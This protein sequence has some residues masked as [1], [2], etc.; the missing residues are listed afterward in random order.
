MSTTGMTEAPKV[1]RLKQIRQLVV[2]KARRFQLEA[3]AQAMAMGWEDRFKCDLLREVIEGKVE[4]KFKVPSKVSR[5][6]WV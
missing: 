4:A 6:E 3:H 2:E 1:D 5:P